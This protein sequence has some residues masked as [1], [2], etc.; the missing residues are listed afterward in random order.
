MKTISLIAIGTAFANY[1]KAKKA[2]QS[3]KEADQA[4]ID[5][6]NLRDNYLR[7]PKL[8]E[9]EAEKGKK[10]IEDFYDNYQS[11]VIAQLEADE[12]DSTGKIANVEVTP[13]VRIGSI[14]GKYCNATI[15]LV[16]KNLSEDRY[17]RIYDVIA[18]ANV[19]GT[20]LHGSMSESKAD[21]NLDPLSSKEIV[22]EKTTCELDENVK[23]QLKAD[24]CEALG[25]KLFSSCIA[26]KVSIAGSASADIQFKYGS[27]KTYAGNEPATYNNQ[28]GILRYVGE[29]Y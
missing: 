25:K 20:F 11:E 12:R 2:Y 8:E 6:L 15:S 21:F 18:E 22:L 24:I 26:L 13:V 19:L 7:F 3:A 23:E 29:G 28:I 17:Y 16:F 9:L 14:N 4:T 1:V 10:A 27:G 5:A